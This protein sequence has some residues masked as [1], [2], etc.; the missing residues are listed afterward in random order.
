MFL[1]DLWNAALQPIFGAAFVAFVLAN[2][3][4]ILVVSSQKLSIAF[5]V[6]VGL[7]VVINAL[8]AVSFFHE[9][10]TPGGYLGMALIVAGVAML[11]K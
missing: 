4:W 10:I 5:P 3:L 11:V 9:K 8:V 7:V 6:Q 1:R 2:F